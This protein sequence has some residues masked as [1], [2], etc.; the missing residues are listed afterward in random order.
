MNAEL[1]PG[2]SI[3][4]LLMF[5]AVGACFRVLRRV[6]WLYVAVLLPGTFLH[7]AAHWLTGFLLGAKPVALTVM[8]RRTVAGRLV[9]GQVAF[10]RL[11]WWNKVPIGLSPLLLLPLA[12]W[13]LSLACLAA[14]GAWISPVLMILAWQCLLSCMPSFRDMTHVVMG[15]IVIAV[16]AI[17]VVLLLELAG[18]P[19][20]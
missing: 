1:I 14:P 18:V 20:V 5:I 11:R 17:G 8:P 6:P 10:T 13:L 19:N 3:G 2:V 4:H 15:A 7:E 12:L 9:Y 16:M